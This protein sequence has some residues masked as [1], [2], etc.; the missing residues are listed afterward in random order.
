MT[1]PGPVERGVPFGYGSGRRLG[2][3][4]YND[5]GTECGSLSFGSA[6]KGNQFEAGAIL[7]FDQYD[8]DQAVVLQQYE[9]NSRRYSGLAIAEYPTGITN[10]QRTSSPSLF[11]LRP[12]S[13]RQERL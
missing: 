2:L 6:K 9:S 7:A 11:P 10:K 12:V 8:Q 3:I 13:S 4:F 5:E 1:P